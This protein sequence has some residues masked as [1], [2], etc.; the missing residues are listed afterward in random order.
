[1]SLYKGQKFDSILVIVDKF[2]KMALYCPT[3]KTATASDLCDLFVEQ[4]LRCFGV[5]KSITSDRGSVF[6]SQ[7]WTEFCI[8]VQM[9]RKLSTSF[10]PQTDGQTERQN[11]TLEIFLRTYCNEEQNDWAALLPIAEFT[12]NNSVHST[13]GTT[14]F[15]AL[16]GKDPRIT[17]DDPAVVDAL[18]KRQKKLH[19]EFQPRLD[20]LLKVQGQIKERLLKAQA[21]QKKWYDQKHEEIYFVPG[22]KVLMSTK[23]LKLARPKKSLWPKY[24]GPL[25]VVENPS[26]HDG[27]NHY[28]LDMP[29][30][31]AIH[32]VVNV[33]RLE[34]YHERDSPIPASDIAMPDIVELEGEDVWNMEAIVD[35]RWDAEKGALYYKV[36]WEGD[37]PVGQKETWEPPEHLTSE[38]MAQYN[39]KRPISPQP[40]KSNVMQKRNTKKRRN[41]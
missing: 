13:T 3:V 31:W 26:G 4:V 18:K 20:R 39:S 15:R 30:N 7:L 1:M 37:W 2:T 29:K 19:P 10:H 12:Y 32:N 11:Q 38:A 40:P 27:P 24:L 28:M 25:T 16:Y 6:L 41:R 22:E 5:P 34:R 21:A 23:N 35:R 9:K 33:S 8:A 36:R 14:P 17:W